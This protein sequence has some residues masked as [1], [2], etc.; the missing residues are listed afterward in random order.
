MNSRSSNFYC[1]LVK[2][3]LKPIFGLLSHVELYWFAPPSC[4]WW[5]LK[6]SSKNLLWNRVELFTKI[7]KINE[8]R[9]ISL[10]FGS[11]F[12]AY[13]ITIA[14]SNIS[15]ASELCGSHFYLFTSAYMVKDKI[16]IHCFSFAEEPFVC[17]KLYRL[18]WVIIESSSLE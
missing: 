7:R 15:T 13:K 18:S 2:V 17:R 16:L 6:I 5:W 10:S 8:N 1:Q 12:G 11:E 14:N 9:R 3:S 4:Y